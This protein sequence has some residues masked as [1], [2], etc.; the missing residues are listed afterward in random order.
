MTEKTNFENAGIYLIR[1]LVNG[2]EYVG[3]TNDLVKRKKRWANDLKLNS[4]RYNVHI[5][6]SFA[7]YDGNFEFSILDDDCDDQFDL[8]TTEIYYIWE[9]D[10]YK[11]G[12]NLTEGGGGSSGYVLT[13]ETR[14]K[15]SKAKKGVKNPVQSKTLK[16]KYASGELVIWNKDKKCSQLS[17]RQMGDKHWLK[18]LSEEEYDYEIEKRSK[19]MKK[20]YATGELEPWNKGIKCP[21]IGEAQMGEKNHMYGKFGEDNP[22]TGRKHTEETIV[23]MKQSANKRWEDPNERLESSKRNKGENNP[24]A[25]LTEKRVRMLKVMFRSDIKTV[26]E[27]SK[28]FGVSEA[29]IRRIKKGEGWSDVKV[30]GW[31]Y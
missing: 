27:L 19:T 9:R 7:K 28:I 4:T 29:T 2:K 31:D 8:N 1:N 18:K 24:S 30:R 25:I 20:M 21:E 14:K 6:R 26:K 5:K 12:Y 22:N 3:Q 15:I 10:S 13:E 23:K 16:S 17:E 11:H